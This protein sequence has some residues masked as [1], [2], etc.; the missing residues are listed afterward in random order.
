MYSLSL[1]MNK[2]ETAEFDLAKQK[3]LFE[4]AEEDAKAAL[5]KAKQANT[6]YEAAKFQVETRGT[7]K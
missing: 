1:D 4:E 5:A 3:V 2:L 6:R 7:F